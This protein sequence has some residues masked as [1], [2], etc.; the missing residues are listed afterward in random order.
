MKATT[1]KA[2][3][4]YTEEKLFKKGWVAVSN[5]YWDKKKALFPVLIVSF[6]KTTQKDLYEQMAKLHSNELDAKLI[7]ALIK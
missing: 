7:E 4:A 1:E 6:I 3:E 5:E 2:F